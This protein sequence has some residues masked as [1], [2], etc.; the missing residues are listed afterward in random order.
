[1]QIWGARIVS[2]VP[3]RVGAKFDPLFC[4]ANEAV[5]GS[6]GPATVI[7]DFAGAPLPGVWYAVALANS[8]AGEDL[9]PDADD[10]HATFNSDLGQ[11]D[12]LPGASWYYGLDGNNPGNTIDLLDTIL[13]EF[14]H[15]FGFLST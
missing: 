2:S 14:V 8:I 9:D 10:I 6:A 15:G 11:A 4:T 5:L 13:H 7:R 3:I 12:C 1:A